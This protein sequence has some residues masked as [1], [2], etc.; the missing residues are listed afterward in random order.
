MIVKATSLYTGSVLTT[1]AHFTA[2]GISK[3]QTSLPGTQGERESAWQTGL[4]EISGE[5][6]RRAMVQNYNH[7]I[8]IN[9]VT[10]FW[11]CQLTNSIRPMVK[12]GT[13]FELP[14]TMKVSFVRRIHQ[15]RI[16]PLTVAF[17]MSHRI[18]IIGL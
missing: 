12:A 13:F 3:G 1:S 16:V 9:N 11:V 5:K 7:Y 4:P 15:N 8:E 6:I 2:A 14:C 10:T 18:V 17:I